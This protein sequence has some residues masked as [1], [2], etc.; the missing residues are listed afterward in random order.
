MDMWLLA[1]EPSATRQ[2]MR[3]AKIGSWAGAEGGR[4]SF[5]IKVVVSEALAGVMRVVLGSE[6]WSSVA[7]VGDS[8]AGEFPDI[9]TYLY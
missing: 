3:S 9:E 2:Y 5:T 8:A 1:S 7:C 6:Y 4:V